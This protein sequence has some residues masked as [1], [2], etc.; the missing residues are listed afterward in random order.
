MK[1][2]YWISYNGLNKYKKCYVVF[3]HTYDSKA[4]IQSRQLSLSHTSIDHVVSISYVTSTATIASDALSGTSN[5][6]EPSAVTPG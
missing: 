1:V 4:F 2:I 6:S 3:I 5:T